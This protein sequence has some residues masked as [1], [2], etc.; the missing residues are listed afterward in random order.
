MKVFMLDNYDSF[1]YNLVHYLQQLNAQVEVH[2]N[3][4][5]SI[6]QIV[7]LN[8]E[9]IV[10]SP[11]PGIP[12]N[13]GIAMD[14]VRHFAPTIP[15]LGVCLGHQ[16]IARVFG[17]EV[18]RARRIMHGKV[19]RITHDGKKIYRNIA[20]PFTATRYHSLIVQK[21]TLPDCLQTTA[22]SLNEQGERDE[23]MGIR[24]NQY[25]VEGM[26]FHPEA[27]MSE[28]GHALLQ[29]FIAPD[30]LSIQ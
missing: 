26:Q 28:H 18:V 20:C 19:S 3:D 16:C 24:H 6:E 11:G 1:T 27:V 9:R 25:N 5:I 13:S 22:W 23:I 29:N 14:L 15:I 4:E 12:E 21:E 30:R 10:I 8:P 17:G 7:T 2:R